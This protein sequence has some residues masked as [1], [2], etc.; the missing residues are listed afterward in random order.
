MLLS[1]GILLEALNAEHAKHPLLRDQRQI[2]HGR[3]RLRLGAISESTARMSVFSNV[4]GSFRYVV[5][6]NRLAMIDT[7][8]SQLVLVISAAGVWCITL[9]VFDC[10]AVLND[11]PFGPVETDAENTCVSYLVYAFVKLEQNGFKIK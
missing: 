6:Q 1:V 5:E 8:N 2:D 4:F 11:M 3:R 7:P 10:E 9:P